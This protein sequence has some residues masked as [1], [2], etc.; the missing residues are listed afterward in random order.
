MA[1]WLE[2]LDLAL[3]RLHPHHEVV[4]EIAKFLVPILCRGPGQTT[5]VELSIKFCDIIFGIF[6]EKRSPCSKHLLSYLRIY[7]DTIINVYLNGAS[8]KCESANG[9]SRKEHCKNYREISLTPL[10]L[11]LPPVPGEAEAGAGAGAPQCPQHH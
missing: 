1:L 5:E 9:Y 3:T 4:I 2:L 10:N 7:K 11:G 6:G 8:L